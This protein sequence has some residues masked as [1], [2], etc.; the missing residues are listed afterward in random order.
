[1][2]G[3]RPAAVIAFWP[4][5]G[6]AETAT[7][8]RLRETAPPSAEV[9]RLDGELGFARALNELAHD[10]GAA[11][12][13][14]VADAGLLPAD[15]FERLRRAGYADD[16]V[17]AA[18]ALA[19]GPGDPPFEGFDCDPVLSPGS[20][21]PGDAPAAAV[22]PRVANLWPQC[23]YI[24]RSA[25]G[26][27]G[28]IDQSLTHPVAGLADLAA[29]ALRLGLTCVLADDVLVVRLE[30][31][32][33]PCPTDQT[34]AVVRSHPWIEA[35]WNEM[36]A[37]ELG[38]LRRSLVAGRVDGRPPSVTVDARAIG[39]DASG[40]QTYVAGLV[41]ALACSE[42][43]T[44][45]ALVRD[46]ARRPALD[47]LERAGVELITETQAADGVARTDI[48]HR[49]QQAFVPEDLR[50][51]RSLGERLVI[52]HLDLISYRNPGYH[53][54]A[55]EWRR[56][57]RLTRVA[58]AACDRVVFLSDHARRDAISEELI[59]PQYT[60]V[61]GV[62]VEAEPTGEAER[63]PDGVP[64]GAELLVMIGS[65]YWHKNRLFALEL[66]GELRSI[67][68]DG[69]LV[70]AGANVAHGGS[71]AA[72]GE[73][74][75]SRPD[76]RSH[77]V[78]LGCVSEPEKRWLLAHATALLCPSTYEGFGLTPLEAALAGIP[79]LYANV[80]SLGEVAGADAATLI[81]WDAAASAERAL[82]LLHAGEARERHLASLRKALGPYRWEA[83]VPELEAV[84][85]EAI[86]SPYRSSA[87][88]AW[89]ELLVREELI[90]ELDRRYQELRERVAF[91]IAL[92]DR[93][94]LLTREQQLGLMRIASRRWLR[95]P[96]LGPL[97]LIGARRDA[98][99]PNSGPSP[100]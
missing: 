18:T 81:P 47:E 60:H 43:G 38:P 70:L 94:G 68:W 39:P 26:L 2:T 79:C 55:D 6:E 87:P 22:H 45:R 27:L 91:G 7:L 80:T 49:P 57:R 69:V 76:L 42:R 12:V 52:T 82:P 77:A 64:E 33:P 20:D 32:L 15:W 73:L 72:E 46:D 5:A 34:A 40:T 95:T 50:L 24:R 23:V 36:D 83:I 16:S 99:G 17:A 96:L 8:D 71:A 88:R 9:I 65:D 41:V 78:D 59:E 67:G 4:W 29:S 1:V 61:C 62:G 44:V 53:E 14:V 56:Y 89:E 90:V 84:Y 85:R 98:P 51:L 86:A 48:A 25:L 11:D 10:S 75:C 58:L 54:S 21:A 92:I 3:A 97:G 74:L 19:A 31:G 37:L 93:D 28:A 35:A 30:G 100:P 13:A 66:L 63:R